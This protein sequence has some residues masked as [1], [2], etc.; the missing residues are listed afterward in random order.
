[1]LDAIKESQTTQKSL[2]SLARKHGVGYD[3]LRRRVNGEVQPNAITGRVQ[4]L[5]PGE[6]DALVLF[7]L[8]MAGQGLGL[9]RAMLKARVVTLV[10]GRPHAFQEHGPSDKW[11]G[12]FLSRHLELAERLPEKLS[13][14]RV[15]GST[16]EIIS[17]HFV[18]LGE[19]IEEYQYPPSLIWNADETSGRING[20][21]D[22][23]IAARGLLFPPLFGSATPK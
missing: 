5:Q 9:T 8:Q 21:E 16:V 23:I 12:Q 2:S 7:A 18:Q 4:G 19:L 20:K 14:L 10:A 11:I 17:R 15:K 22:K 13:T 6:E 1:M 3:A